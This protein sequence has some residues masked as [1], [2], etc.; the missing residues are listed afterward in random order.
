MRSAVLRI[1]ASTLAAVALGACSGGRSSSAPPGDDASTGDD[2]STSAPS[3]TPQ[4][5]SYTVAAPDTFAQEDVALDDQTTPVDPTMGQPQRVRLGLGG[6]TTKGQAGYPDPTTTAAFT[7]ETTEANRAARVKLGTSPS[8]QSTVQTGTT[9]TIHP[10]L[11]PT[12]RFHEV[13]VCG[14]T[15]NTTYFYAVGGG[16][17]GSE[18]WSATQSFTTM[19]ATGTITVGVYGDARDTLATWQAVH[20]RM[21]DAGVLMSLVD[22]DVVAGGSDEDFYTQWLDGVWKDPNNATKFLT[23]GQ[24][25][26]LPINGNHENDQT[27]SFANWAIPGDGPYAKTYA[28][29]DVG[30]AHV[31][32]IDDEQIAYP[33]SAE[34]SAQLAWIDSDLKAAAADRANHPFLVVMSHRGI[35]STSQHSADPDVIATRKALVPIFDKYGVSLVINGHDHEY[36][37]TVPVVAG[38][39]PSSDPLPSAQGTTYVICAGAGAENYAVGTT[40]VAWRATKTAFGPGTPYIGTYALLTIAPTGL[41]MKAYGLKSSSTTVAGDDLLETVNLTH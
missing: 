11:G 34:A 30:A 10:L 16:P 40:P 27:P 24:Q 19:P 6:N 3:Y 41:T 12:T 7:W 28:S 17:A 8:A 31:T 22:G 9:W 2:G 37:R 29:F 39:P 38:N 5:C 14:L 35:Y 1:A 33:P 15:P 36:E 26:I 4:G 25:Y 21:R 23:L 32:L 20:V 13:H 18:V